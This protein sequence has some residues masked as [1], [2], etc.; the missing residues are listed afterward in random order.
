MW[1]SVGGVPDA[2]DYLCVGGVSCSFKRISY[3]LRE[4][5][6]G[7]GAGDWDWGYQIYV[8]PYRS[9]GISSTYSLLDSQPQN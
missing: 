1:D 8:R 3:Y 5:L 2:D 7:F 6:L 9:M 4:L